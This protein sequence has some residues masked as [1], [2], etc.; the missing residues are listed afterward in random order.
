MIRILLLQFEEIIK[1]N[2]I[3]QKK[4][5]TVSIYG[6]I[7]LT[8]MQL[9]DTECHVFMYSYKLFLTKIR[10]NFCPRQLENMSVGE[11]NEY[12]GESRSIV[13]GIT[14]LHTEY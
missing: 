9:I 12:L 10:Q 1:M 11:R 8:L 14:H 6:Y 13:I 3:I 5:V 2:M 7:H 4:N